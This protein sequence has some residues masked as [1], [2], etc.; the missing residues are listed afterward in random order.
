MNTIAE[1]EKRIEQVRTELNQLREVK[2]KDSCDHK[3]IQDKLKEQLFQAQRNFVRFQR[4]SSRGR[5]HEYAHAVQQVRGTKIPKHVIS[6]E[7]QLCQSLHEMYIAD[8]QLQIMKGASRHILGYHHAASE[9]VLRGK[10]TGEHVLMKKIVEFDDEN[11]R[12]SEEFEQFIQSQHETITQTQRKLQE[13]SNDSM[14]EATETMAEDKHKGD[15]PLQQERLEQR[16]IV[17]SFFRA[18]SK[19]WGTNKHNSARR[20]L[21][22]NQSRVAEDQKLALSVKRMPFISAWSDW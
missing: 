13:Q 5:M 22:Q 16:V 7:G 3:V 9:Q 19:T 10:Q 18:A 8:A 1:M 2:S 15:E 12:T 11:K 17:G 6:M 14:S 21:P 20:D 4:K